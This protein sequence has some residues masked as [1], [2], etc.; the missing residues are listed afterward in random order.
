MGIIEVASDA[1]YVVGGTCAWAWV[2]EN[3]RFDFGKGPKD[4]HK[5]ELLGLMHA[6]Y[7]HRGRNHS[8]VIYSDSRSAVKQTKILLG[9]SK[10][11]TPPLGRY[12]FGSPER[13]L[14]ARIMIRTG[15]MEIKWVRSHNDH[16]MNV[17]ADQLA[18]FVRRNYSANLGDNKAIKS[19][20]KPMIEQL[21]KD[22]L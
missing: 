21:L 6:I 16:P 19:L 14:D 20:A 8:Y 10:G 22:S 15:Q 2:D 17:A 3:L 7:E 1:S 5:L 9:E 11:Y 4:T 12:S 13:W 18:T